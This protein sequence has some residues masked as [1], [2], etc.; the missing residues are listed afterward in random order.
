MIDGYVRSRVVY[1][2]SKFE[3]NSYWHVEMRTGALIN[4]IINRVGV[5]VYWLAKLQSKLV[6][7][8]NN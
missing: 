3:L 7:K 5:L 2:K 6:H 8:K 1:D 4:I